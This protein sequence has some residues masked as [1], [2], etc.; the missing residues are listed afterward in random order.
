ML[1]RILERRHDPYI[2]L[3]GDHRA[4]FVSHRVL[5]VPYLANLPHAAYVAGSDPKVGARSLRPSGKK[6]ST[7]TTSSNMPGL[8]QS[9]LIKSQ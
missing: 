8:Q 3:K 9:P 1:S 2:T 5:R 6:G 7:Q 4:I